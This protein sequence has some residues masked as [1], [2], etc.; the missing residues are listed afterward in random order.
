MINLNF[1]VFFLQ[2]PLPVKQIHQEFYW[3]PTI[4][5]FLVIFLKMGIFCIKFFHINYYVTLSYSSKNFSNSSPVLSFFNMKFF[6]KI[7]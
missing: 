6:F 1:K 5:I 2:N 4:S 3:S 7:F